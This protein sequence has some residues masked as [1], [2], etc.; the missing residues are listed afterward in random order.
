MGTNLGFLAEL[1]HEAA[2][3]RKVL[4]RIPAD[5]AEFTPHPKS[6]TLGKLATHLADMHSWIAVTVNTTELD[7][8]SGNY[9]PE[10][11]TTAE[12]LTAVFDKH[13]ADG[14]TALASTN[15]EA[16]SQPWT[17]RNGEHHIFTMPRS[18]CLRSFVFNHIVHHRAQLVVYL[19]LLDVPVPGLYGPSADER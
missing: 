3:T 9:V 17:L 5:K 16:L 18:A 8:A 13:V 11:L 1:E 2:N 14:K 7:F 12:A 6:F 4:E 19:R 15:D 10:A